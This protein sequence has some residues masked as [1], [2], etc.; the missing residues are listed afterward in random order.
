MATSCSLFVFGKLGV[1]FR[2]V[3]VFTL[4]NSSKLVLLFK[5]ILKLHMQEMT[6]IV[7]Q[8]VVS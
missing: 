2:C 3:I 4:L 1:V 6:N 5:N 8:H 7:K